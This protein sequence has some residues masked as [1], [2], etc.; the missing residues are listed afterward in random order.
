MDSI[1]Q[2][3]EESLQGV[4]N[5]EAKKKKKKEVDDYSTSSWDLRD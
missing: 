1:I 2:S 3:F 5:L 4:T